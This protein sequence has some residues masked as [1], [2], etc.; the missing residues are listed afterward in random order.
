ME[1]LLIKALATFALPPGINLVVGVVGWLVAWRR[2]RLGLSLVA[3]ALASLYLLATGG[4][5][6]PLV[7]SLETHPPL[8]P[9]ALAGRDAG[10]IVILAG[11]RDAPA[12][13]FGEATVS[14]NTLARLRYG[15]RVYFE[16]GLPVLVSG[17]RVFGG[18]ESEAVLMRETLVR[19]FDVPVRWVE[20][21]S[22]NTAENAR[23]TA[24]LLARQD[25]TQV[26]L[27]TD[28]T[29]M[30]RAVMMFE[31]A[32]LQVIPAPTGFHL[33]DPSTPV[34]LRWLPSAGALQA[35]ATAFYEYLGRIWYR[36]RY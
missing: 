2:R 13:E 15:A 9:A 22:R 30:T 21:Q 10:A 16:T 3:V 26:I 19:D 4:V 11:G 32:G 33:P 36:L 24:A 7:H 12:P 6:Q 34:L 1:L 5:A 14:R 17:G 20:D 35:S 31:R 18:G 23:R 27:V 29:H 8:R 25:I 28:A